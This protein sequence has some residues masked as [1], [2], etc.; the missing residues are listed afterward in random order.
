[1]AIVR[2]DGTLDFEAL[3]AKID[4]DYKIMKDKVSSGRKLP[5]IQIGETPQIESTPAAAAKVTIY[6]GAAVQI[7]DK[8]S[9]QQIELKDTKGEMKAIIN[10]V[11][12]DLKEKAVSGISD[13][14]L[15]VGAGILVLLLIT[16]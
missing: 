16:R 6:D 3:K 9:D 1:M 11:S 12:E 8:I 15:L 14:L 4:S 2:N 10:E 13:K 5:Q 7:S